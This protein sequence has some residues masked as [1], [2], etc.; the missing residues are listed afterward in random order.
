MSIERRRNRILP[1]DW[2]IYVNQNHVSELEAKAIEFANQLERRAAEIQARKGA[3]QKGMVAVHLIVAPDQTVI[4]RALQILSKRGFS[5]TGGDKRPGACSADF[6]V[7][8]LTTPA[9]R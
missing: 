6:G 7:R 9:H 8:K 5:V 1:P 4:A 2:E 3:D